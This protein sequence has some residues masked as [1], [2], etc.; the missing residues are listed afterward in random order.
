[1]KN[2]KSMNFLIA[3]MACLLVLNLY[4]TF[5]LQGRLNTI[6]AN[7]LKSQ[8]NGLINN[9][10]NPKFQE[11][12]RLEVS[13]DNDPVKG[14]EDALIEIVEF[15][16]FECPFCARFFEQTLPLLEENYIKTGKVKLVYRDFPLGFHKNAQKAAE[17][18]E[19]ANEQGKFWEYHD[20]IFSNQQSLDIASL[21]QY[22]K[23]VGL[24][25][26]KFDSCLDSGRMSEEV[27]AD[28]RDGAGYGVT[29]TPTFFINGIKLVGAQPYEA[30]KQVIEQELERLG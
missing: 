5:N 9:P 27:R 30:F 6:E 24:D 29:G 28:S 3:V 18:A 19:C 10:N 21:K 11:L 20:K 7:G 22:A 26:L 2:N 12:E 23:D 25:A 15:S 1:M 14:S 4:L 13:S 8:D 17:A 16:D